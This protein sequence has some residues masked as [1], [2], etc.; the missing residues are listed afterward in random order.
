[1]S[2][3]SG[4]T[5]HHR[6]CSRRFS[7]CGCFYSVI[8]LGSSAVGILLSRLA[9]RVTCWRTGPLHTP[10]VFSGSVQGANADPCSDVSR[11][12]NVMVLVETAGNADGSAENI[13]VLSDPSV[14]V[15]PLMHNRFRSIRVPAVYLS[16]QIRNELAPVAS[17]VGFS[18]RREPV[19]A[20]RRFPS[21]RRA[22]AMNCGPLRKGQRLRCAAG[23]A[24]D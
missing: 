1:V 2:R 15:R 8:G 11:T 5:F 24:T 23:L 4:R 9:R 19:I 20:A 7:R 6:P 21:R 3:R 10:R 22:L 12:R 13:R 16:V 14:V 17:Y 18:L